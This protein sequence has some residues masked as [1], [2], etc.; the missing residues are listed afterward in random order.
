MPA[1]RGR[2]AA[3]LLMM[4]G[5]LAACGGGG[6][7]SDDGGPLPPPPPPP[8]PP[9][10]AV[11]ITGSVRFERVPFRAAP[12]TGLDYANPVL[13]PA[14]GVSV[15][16]LQ[17]G[18]STLLAAGRTDDDGV[19]ALQVPA[20][21]SVVIQVLAEMRHGSAGE[22]PR[23][24]VRVQD[25][26]DATPFTFTSATFDSNGGGLDLAIPSGISAGGTATGPRASGPF[27]ILD[28]IHAAID[29]VLGVEP[30]ADLPPLLVDWGSQTGGSYFQAQGNRQFIALNWDLSEDT[31]E[32]D[33][34]VIAHEYGH[35]L[36]H[37]FSRSD[38]IGGDHGLGDRLDPR[39][40][41]GEGFGYA[42][43][44]I[45][46][47]D[48]VLRDSFVD[49]GTQRDFR[50]SLETNPSGLVTAPQ[51]GCWCSESSVW[52]ILWDL[53]DASN[54]GVDTL[55][56]G[57]Q[58]IWDVMKGAHR[59][60]P[61]V[62]SIFSFIT[63]LKQA[64]PQDA[65]AIDALVA[66]QNIDAAVIDAFASAETHAPW[67]GALPLFTDIA[68]GVP[69]VVQSVDNGGRYNKLGN[70]R[71]LRFVPGSSRV[72]EVELATSNPDVNADPDFL[73]LR[74]GTTVALAESPPPGSESV[75]FSAAAG[76]TYIIDAY[77]CAN[78]CRPPPQGTPGD[79]DLTVTI[80]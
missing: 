20:G 64:R 1:R 16:A 66:A 5:G 48:P 58:P 53:H 61:A 73:V 78:G 79:Y 46:L 3:L 15:R 36:E 10:D 72:H 68:P 22:L 67:P 17:A 63:A 12:G 47:G 60:T 14:R 25:G 23:W 18:S 56:L 33:Q 59:S 34:H 74:H 77:D 38:S 24:D 35:Y 27:A 30:Q 26:L 49:N 44:A 45:A 71:F 19:Y 54:E 62:T 13:R 52:S 29:A 37:N 21:R 75:A 7:S 51:G 4:M 8:P 42:F 80:Q 43:A 50:V 11:T 55:T 69:V 6:S 31:E 2:V 9:A 40:A 70:R 28:T 39:V 65:A 32:F 57:F 76:Q 41:F